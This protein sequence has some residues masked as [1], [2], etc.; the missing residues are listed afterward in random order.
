MA[1]K[2]K[3][4]KFPKGFL[5]GAATSAYQVEG[6]ITNNDWAGSSRFPAAGTACDHYNRYEQDFILAKELNQ[7]AQRLSLEWSRIEPKED[8]WSEEALE[9]YFHV[10]KFLKYNG[11]TTFVTL[12]HFTN[13]LWIAERGGWV[14]GQTIEHF[15]SY[16]AKIAQSLG[17]FIDFWMTFNEPNVYAVMSFIQGIWP[18]FERSLWQAN[19]VYRHM[20]TAHNR[21]YD[22]I[23][24]YYPEARVGFAQN[25]AFN[26]PANK[27]SIFDSIVAKL[28]DWI[29]IDFALN[30]TKYD[31]IGLNHYFHHHLKFDWRKVS[32]VLE[33]HGE[34]TDKGWEVYPKAIYHVLHKLKKFRKPIYIT[35]NGIADVKDTKRASYLRE[36][37]KESYYA[38][39]H[40]VPVKGYFYWSLLDNYEWP[41]KAGE[42]GYE[43]KFG[44]VAVDF[45]NQKR[46]IRD[47]AHR[48]AAICRSNELVL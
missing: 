6:G 33:P 45:A 2:A 20:L 8:E 48:Y 30:K 44:L 46:T 26:E 12:H 3:T 13:P 35:E 47:S 24:A 25:V 36:Y 4:L 22:I 15:V 28:T 39:K 1:R 14:R 18:P 38:L 42:T 31:F 23:H 32:K 9:H 37:L 43:S 7:N 29:S 40:G 5:W 16:V 34:L 11:F 41:V 27:K 19:L 17:Q 21:A 10:L